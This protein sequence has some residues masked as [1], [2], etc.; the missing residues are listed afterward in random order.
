M[1]YFKPFYD[2]FGFIH[3]IDKCSITFIL[4]VQSDSIFSY[5][6]D[7]FNKISDFYALKPDIKENLKPVSAM[8][9]AKH[10]YRFL[11]GLCVFIGYYQYVDKFKDFKTVYNCRIEFNPNK[12]LVADYS[13]KDGLGGR[14]IILDICNYLKGISS[15]VI[16]KR[17]DYSCDIPVSIDDV[18]V[19]VSKK[20]KQTYKDTL[21]FGAPGSHGRLKIYNKTIES[22][23]DYDCTRI[24]YTFKYNRG[25]NFEKIYVCG[26]GVDMN[27]IDNLTSNTRVL[28]R[29][30][31][32][33]KAS[34]IDYTL[35]LKDLNSR[36]RKEVISA[37]EDAGLCI[38][39]DEDLVNFLVF[40]LSDYLGLDINKIQSVN[41]DSNGFIDV[42]LENSDCPFIDA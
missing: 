41:V 3:S 28:V 37:V 22:N 39:F 36:K 16:I 10:F 4:K 12:L 14:D 2:E 5:I 24:E 7:Y 20:N 11:Y 21:Y 32:A 33:L 1:R 25:L 8:G 6:I 42:D 27:K 29:L 26:G 38:K 35:Y 9:W 19:P 15:D 23:L 34:D 17:V 40:Q 31:S 18:I 13:F 30:C